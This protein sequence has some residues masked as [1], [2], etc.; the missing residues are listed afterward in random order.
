[1]KPNE[2]PQDHYCPWCGM[3]RKFSSYGTQVGYECG[4]LFDS[5]LLLQRSP[6]CVRIASLNMEIAILRGERVIGFEEWHKSQVKQA[7]AS[8]EQ[9]TQRRRNTNT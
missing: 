7:E 3:D 1:M 6:S 2:M 5:D 9:N 8:N 4:S